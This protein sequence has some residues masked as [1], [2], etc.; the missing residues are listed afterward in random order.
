MM[1][2]DIPIVKQFQNGTYRL[3]AP[4][5][6]VARV[7]QWLP[8]MGITRIANITNLDTIGIPVVMACRPNS[9]SISV[10][11]GKGLTLAA[12]RASGLME[13]IETYHAESITLPLK[14][15]SYEALRY[16]HPVVDVHQLPFIKN[17]AFHPE[18]RL[19]WIEGYDLIQ[20]DSLWL[21]YEMVHTDYT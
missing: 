2:S 14:L 5:E 10:S 8:I 1:L 4:E 16:T 19:L 18:R 21:P 12:A 15:A 13:S 11:Q 7:K 3:I 17:S 6:T 20:K 9:R